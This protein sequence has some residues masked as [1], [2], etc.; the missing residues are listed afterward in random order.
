MEISRISYL[1]I[2]R[3]ESSESENE[4]DLV[5]ILANVAKNNKKC[6]LIEETELN[7]EKSENTYEDRKNDSVLFEREEDIDE[8][9]LK[10]Y[11]LV[12]GI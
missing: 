7:S 11:Q 4:G 2:F 5:K 3:V 12:Y 6:T 10:F 9:S 1:P 8:D